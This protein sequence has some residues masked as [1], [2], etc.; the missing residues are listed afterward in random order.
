M[1]LAAMTASAQTAGQNSD[2]LYSKESTYKK[3]LREE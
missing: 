2:S 1:C 3:C